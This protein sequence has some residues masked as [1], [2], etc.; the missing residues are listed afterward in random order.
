MKPQLNYVRSTTCK[1]PE[2][3]E[4]Q[5]MLEKANLNS[6]TESARMQLPVVNNY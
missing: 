4:I 6:K 5:K 1:R 3:K 2:Q